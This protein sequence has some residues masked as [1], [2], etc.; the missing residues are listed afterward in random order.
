MAPTRRWAFE[1]RCATRR[2]GDLRRATRRLEARRPATCLEPP[3]SRFATTRA[4]PP[5]LF[6]PHRLVLR[7]EPV[8]RMDTLGSSPGSF[9]SSH[10]LIDA[11][12]GINA[13]P[14]ALA[15]ESKDSPS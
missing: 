13:A 11:L 3:C 12:A 14:A 7:A 9:H 6:A 4:T 2:P 1:T 8:W 10:G 5:R 15:S